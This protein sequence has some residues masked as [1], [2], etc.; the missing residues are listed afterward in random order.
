MV[1]FLSIRAQEYSAVV[2]VGESIDVGERHT[3]GQDCGVLDFCQYLDRFVKL[4][5]RDKW[6]YKANV[7]WPSAVA[8]VIKRS[9]AINWRPGISRW[10]NT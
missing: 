5:W 9:E 2:S 8:F 3:M 6:V 4:V 7:G 1:G 10:Q